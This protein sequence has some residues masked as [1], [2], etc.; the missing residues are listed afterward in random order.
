MLTHHTTAYHFLT[1]GKRV[2]LVLFSADA[3]GNMV[4]THILICIFLL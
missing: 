1:R 4:C 2:K 3:A